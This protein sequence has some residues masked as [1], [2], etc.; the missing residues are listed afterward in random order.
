MRNAPKKHMVV[1]VYRAD[2]GK[3]NSPIDL[4]CDDVSDEEFRVENG[5]EAEE[6]PQK[7]IK[8]D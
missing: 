5:K 4:D 1:R 6:R 7:R 3:E 8:V 2:E